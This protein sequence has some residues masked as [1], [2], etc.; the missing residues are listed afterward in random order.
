MCC[1]LPRINQSMS[2][3]CGQDLLSWDQ[4]VNIIVPIIFYLCSLS[5]F[6]QMFCQI[7]NGGSENSRYLGV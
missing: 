6:G 5:I 4:Y 3:R 2:E 7:D 1:K